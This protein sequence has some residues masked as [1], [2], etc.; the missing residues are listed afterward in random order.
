MPEL[1]GDTKATATAPHFTAQVARAKRP[2]TA[3]A[4]V[5]PDQKAILACV[6]CEIRL[7]STFHGTQLVF[8]D[9][10]TES[11]RDSIEGRCGLRSDKLG[12]K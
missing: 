1:V 4:R 12:P 3:R 5:H 7:D 9:R 8:L 6:G 10:A 2:A 11:S